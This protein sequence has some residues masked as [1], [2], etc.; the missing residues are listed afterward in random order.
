MKRIIRKDTCTYVYCA[1][2]YNSQNMEATWVSINRWI[3]EIWYMYIRSDQISRSV[4]SDSLR[5]HELQH[6]RPP[7]PSPTPGVHWD[8]RPSSQ[9]K[10][11]HTVEF[12]F[13]VKRNEIFP[14]A[15]TWTNL[16][17]I[18]LS[19]TSQR[20]TNTAWFHLYVDSKK[21]N[22]WTNLTKENNR[23]R[24]KLVVATGEVA[25]GGEK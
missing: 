5:P 9:C 6:A 12:Y 15:T 10:H 24:N 3:K 11:T 18:M 4:M 16:E 13:A 23:Y 7:C 2:I 1:I 25:E 17:G 8:S 14:F 22:K 20:K 21:Q 19:E